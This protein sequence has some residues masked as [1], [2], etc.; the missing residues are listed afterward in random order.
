MPEATATEVMN[1]FSVN[2]NSIPGSSH[3]IALFDEYRILKWEVW[4][5]S[6]QP[7]WPSATGNAFTTTSAS[8]NSSHLIVAVDTIGTSAQA[9]N[10]VLAYDNSVVVQPHEDH[11]VE[12]KPSA[13]ANIGATNNAAPRKSPW[14][15]VGDP[16]CPHYGILNTITASGGASIAGCAWDVIQKVHVQFREGIN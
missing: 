16:S 1:A 4:F 2:L 8:R 6:R 13:M 7:A 9:G 3:Y 12:V 14:I 11:Y 15:S 5:K 10:V